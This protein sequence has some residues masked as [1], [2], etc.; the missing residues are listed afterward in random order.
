[1]K[2]VKGSRGVPC[3]LRKLYNRMQLY[4]DEYKR[5]QSGWLPFTFGVDYVPDMSGDQLVK[6]DRAPYKAIDAKEK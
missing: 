2:Y 1:M 4:L 5:H 3:T 6:F